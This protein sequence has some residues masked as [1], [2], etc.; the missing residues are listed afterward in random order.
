MK[1]TN[2]YDDLR[3]EYKNNLKKVKDNYPVCFHP[4]HHP[5]MHIVLEPDEYK[6]TC[7]GCG[8]VTIFNVPGSTCQE[9]FVKVIVAGS[10]EITSYIVVKDAIKNSGYD[11]TEIVS[12]TAR[13]ADKL[14]E[15]WAFE[16]DIPVKRFPADWKQYGKSAGYKRN[17]Q[18]AEY[19][20][21][22]VA[23]WDGKS[24]GTGHMISIAKMKQ[25]PVYI[26]YV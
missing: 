21:A 3:N 25:M 2:I 19:A 22:L 14:G 13:G 12:G 18:M 11:V 26:H 7:P 10:R 6:Y 1:K 16:N 15:L 17:Q 23:V 8:H 4:A 5:P 9:N 20:D 24:A